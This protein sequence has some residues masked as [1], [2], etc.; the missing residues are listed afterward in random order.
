MAGT[1]VTPPPAAGIPVTDGSAAL[2]SSLSASDWNSF[3][4]SAVMDRLLAHIYGNRKSE[5][6]EF[7]NLCLSLARSIDFAIGNNEVPSRS[8][9]LPSLVKKV[10]CQYKTDSVLQ[11]SIMVLMISVKSACQT[12]WFSV[13]DSDELSNL[14]KE[15]ETNFCSVSNCNNQP[16]HHLSIISTI[17][18][19]F[20]PRIKLGHI[21]ALLEVKP[22]YDAYVKDFQISKNISTSPQDK[23]RLL[24]VQT[25]NTETSA[26]LVSPAK[27]NFLLNG[28]GVERRTNHSL[29]TGPQIPTIVNNLLKYGTNLLQAVGEFNGNYC[30]A[31]AFTSEVPNPDNNTLQDYEQHAPATVDAD[32]EIIVG[33]SR[34]SLNCPISFKKIKTPVKGHSC[35]HIQCFD[36]DNYVD[37]NSRRPSW[38]CPHCNQH[39]SFTDIRIDQKM[40]K[41]LKEAGSH[42][43]N[44]TISSDGSWSATTAETDDTTQKP[45]D[46]APNL[47]RGE[48]PPGPADILDLTEIDDV[49]S[50]VTPSEAE[51]AK[52]LLTAAQNSMSRACQGSSTQDDFWS[53]V[54]LST[55]GD[56]PSNAR[57]SSLNVSTSVSEGA[58]N[59]ISGPSPNGTP[60][61]NAPQMQQFQFGNTNESGRIS[62]LPPRNVTRVPVGVQALPVQTQS[63]ARSCYTNSGNIMTTNNRPVASQV[64]PNY[65]TAPLSHIRQGLPVSSSPSM[66]HSAVQRNYSFPS[67]E[68]QRSSTGFQAPNAY[69]QQ[70][71]SQASFLRQPITTQ[72][73]QLIAAANRAVQMSFEP[74]RPVPTSYSTITSPRDQMGSQ[75]FAGPDGHNLAAE[76]SWRPVARMRGALSGQAYTEAYNQAMSRPV[77]PVAQGVRPVPNVT[78]M[79]DPPPGYVAGGGAVQ[80]VAAGTVQSVPTQ[81]HVSSGTGGSSGGPVGSGVGPGGS[82]GMG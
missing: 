77:Q 59:A 53:A 73:S 54:F 56:V 10:V 17:M 18:S 41:I 62:T 37:I 78:S 4:M 26:C 51:D 74:M 24:V 67:A 69:V 2:K 81:N 3:R 34:I 16:D 43:S 11:A 42:V 25:D 72:H 20:Y 71:S 79:L 47:G 28:R 9:D 38:R 52:H 76:M 23:I 27:V 6:V 40:F 22:G 66:Q 32:S 33:P 61:P 64:S 48:S 80:G 68:P 8:P 1:A 46:V 31:V 36:F 57:P 70:P 12:G 13:A 58:F 7:L 75:P 35:K 63:S 82:S 45:N 15:I 5:T 60:S 55:F 19:R 30:I 49:M 44:V 39:V 50:E 65:S 14:T 21:L 29:D